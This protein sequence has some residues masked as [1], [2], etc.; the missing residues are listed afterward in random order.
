MVATRTHAPVSTLIISENDADSNICTHE[1]DCVDFLLTFTSL[2]YNWAM[3]DQELSL[4]HDTAPI[5]SITEL[6]T[7][8]PCSERLWRAQTPVEWFDSVQDT[9]ANANN[10]EYH[11]SA[12]PQDG[13][14]LSHLFQDMLRD[15]LELKNRQLSPLTLKLLLHPLHSQVCHL[16][17]LL[18]CFYG[19]HDNQHSTRPITT[20][21]TLM[22]LEE[23]QSSLQ[24]W[25]ELCM[26]NAKSSPECPITN[27]SLVLYHLISLNTVS[28]F[29]EIERLV[30]KDGFDGLSWEN[31]LRSRQFIY[32]PESAHFHCG[33]ILRIISCMPKMGRP[34]WWSAAIYRVT[35]TLWVSSISRAYADPE[36][37]EKGPVVMINSVTPDDPSLKAY[38]CNLQGV[39]ALLRRDGSYTQLG[40]PDDVLT[41]CLTLIDEGV[42]TRFSDGI[43]RKLRR[44]LRNWKST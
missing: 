14:S 26:M 39:P 31:A 12:H 2:V 20:A 8:L 24:K 21:S 3:I 44:V 41:Y 36:N 33:Q 5:L 7:P 42:P 13:F 10:P 40:N 28:Y 32:K 16:G 1:A 34:P 22:R 6:Q 23:V 27:G 15:E 25:Y 30:R 29:P 9:Y 35:M 37:R 18:S 38:L 19:M 11:S 17:Q 43:R 4:F